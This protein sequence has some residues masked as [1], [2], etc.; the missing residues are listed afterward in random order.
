MYRFLSVL[1]ICLRFYASQECSS[2][3]FDFKSYLNP[4]LLD[5]TTRPGSVI[6]SF[7]VEH[8]QSATV[9]SQDNYI[10]T[11]ING[12]E[13]QFFTTEAFAQYE[14]REIQQIL[15][16]QVFY[17]CTS[18]SVAG[19][20]RQYFKLANNHA[21]RF[22]AE[23]YEA[24]VPLPLPKHFDLSPYLGNGV[25]IMARD[26]DLINNTVTFSISA[27][28]YMLVE[29]SVVKDD[30]KQFKA[31]LRLK[32]QV[33][34][35]P[36]K[37]ELT[38]TAVDAGIPQRS[39]EVSVIIE[40]D[41]SIV[42]EDP[43][44][45]KETFINRTIEQDLLL[46]LELI[47]GTETSDVQYSVEGTDAKFFTLAVWT[48]NTGV[49][50]KVTNLHTLPVAK[51]FLNVVVVA[52]R[53]QLQKTSCV[54]LL[55]IPPE[56]IPDPPNTTVEKVL[57]VLHLKEMSEHRDIFPLVIDSCT[58][59]VQSQTPGDYF[60]IQD[61]S[62]SSK[63]FNREDADLFAGLDFPQF[64]IVLRLACSMEIA[65]SYNISNRLGPMRDIEFSTDLTH[66]NIIVDDINDNSPVFTFPTNNARVAFPSPQLSR[67]LLPDQ[68]LTVEASDLDE[69]INAVIRYSLA[70]NDHFDIDPQTGV[71]FPL[72]SAFVL[73][74]SVTI[75][76]F[77]TDRDGAEDGNTSTMKLHVHKATDDQLV[78]LTVSDID[79]D[80][81]QRALQEI[82]AKR[83]IQ[84]E[85]IR[86]VYSVETE[87]S[88]LYGRS[89][90]E[91]RYTTTAIVYAFRDDQ[92][93]LQDELKGVFE[94]LET[95]LTV[96]VSK[97]NELYGG[98]ATIIDSDTTVIYP[99]IIATAFCGT[100]AV[101][102]AAA[103]CYYRAKTRHPILANDSSTSPSRSSNVSDAIIVENDH[104]TSSSTPPMEDH[105][106][107]GVILTESVDNPRSLSDL[108]T[109]T[110][111]KEHED[112]KAEPIPPIQQERK[113]S[114]KFNENVER[115]EVF[116]GR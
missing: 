111:E 64:W 73:E 30:L 20:Y 79:P 84:I 70:M 33:L 5:L 23:T 75:E 107:S 31:S 101:A 82:S 28:D 14:E 24:L 45:F 43:P 51:S 90:S 29:S 32:E 100:L 37:L 1:A 36:H 108:L 53:S 57:S 2:P 4:E 96:R 76:I 55:N 21:P 12:A 10:E 110:E 8:V 74:E 46:Q 77:A 97:M 86:S 63:V 68:L 78:A 56:S 41:L 98:S 80:T 22:L 19:L 114:I 6:A 3:T 27:N 38:V 104:K 58:Y 93:L 69:G 34:K 7:P 88:N 65:E 59:S 103:A 60:F 91:A 115:I 106:I 71:I 94:S 42:Y 112:N 92:L 47:P 67:K 62:L 50:L 16:I 35:M 66:L 40:P 54:V 61:A 18:G 9:Q 48:N 13:L 15:I 89:A 83:G 81:F 87:T 85:T 44:E 49:D 102:M 72:K 95:N 113:K 99:Y 11:R 116:D 26:I 39:S 25:G 109:I 17:Q 52:K 105:K